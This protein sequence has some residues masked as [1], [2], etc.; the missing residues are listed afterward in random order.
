RHRSGR[1]IITTAIEHPSVLETVNYL[2][3]EG[4]KV[5]K[6]PVDAYGRVTADQVRDALTEDTILVSCM[7]V[8]NELGTKEP[9]EE[10]GLMLK[11]ERPDVLFHVDAVQGYGKYRLRPKESGIDLLSVSGHKI[12]G[13]KGIGFLYVRKGV[14]VR[15]I[16][17]GGG[18]QKGLRS[19]TENVPGIAGMAAAAEFIYRNFEADISKMYGLR[20]RLMEGLA[21]IDGAVVNSIPGDGGAPHIVNVSFEGIRSE[22]L[23]HALEDKGIYVSSG[24]A[25]A[26]N[27]PG[28]S[29]VL[30]AAGIPKKRIEGTIRL[31]LRPETSSEEIDVVLAAVSEVVPFYSRLRRR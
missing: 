21:A 13:P 2:E 11:K 14:I 15:P 3:E 10:I 30:L 12:H 8:N 19:G 7:M 29:H 17:F 31:S 23:L 16:I 18:Q 26:S 24:S 9:V 4:Y 28:L 25:C 22:V 27:H 20:S 6:L 1:H 5:T